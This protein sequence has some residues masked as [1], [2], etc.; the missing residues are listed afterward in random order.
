MLEFAGLRM[1]LQQHASHRK[2]GRLTEPE[3]SEEPSKGLTLAALHTAPAAAAAVG[4]AS[5]AA[6]CDVCKVSAF[7]VKVDIGGSRGPSIGSLHVHPVLEDF[8][9]R[10]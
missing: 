8:R 9:L 4:R 7:L 6:C 10:S 5:L 1:R 2:A 3:T